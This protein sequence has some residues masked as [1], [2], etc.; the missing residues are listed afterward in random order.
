MD[1]LEDLRDR[2]HF[3]AAVREWDQFHTP[4]NLAKS[5]SIEANELLELF[6]WTDRPKEDPAPEMADVLIYLIRMADVM[7]IDLVKAAWAKIVENEK[8]YPVE[9]CKGRS[10]KYDEL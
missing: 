1:S 3:F 6:Q 10:T 9:K 7:G 4:I 8:K 2:L 5:V